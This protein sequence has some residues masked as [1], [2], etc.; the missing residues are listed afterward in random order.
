MAVTKLEPQQVFSKIV[1]TLFD[2][3]WIVGHTTNWAYQIQIVSGR[4]GSGNFLLEVGS[5]ITVDITQSGANGLDTGSEAANTWYFIWLIYNPT[6][7]TLAGLLSTSNSSPTMP[8]GYTEKRRI[9][10]VRND[11]SSN[12]LR[13][14]Q[15]GRK[16]LYASAVGQVLSFG[17]ATV[18]TAVDCSAFVPTNNNAIG[19][20]CLFASSVVGEVNNYAGFGVDGANAMTWVYQKYTAS[21]GDYMQ[22]A[23]A[24]YFHFANSN[25]PTV[26]YYNGGANGRFH[27]YILGFEVIV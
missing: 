25:P 5:T 4:V 17:S 14:V 8:S 11:S 15:F 20:H 1:T 24:G 13:F 2:N 7:G 21:V 12:L 19:V 16:V 22:D 3:V 10:A 26:Y 6:T 18:W 27:I 23:S 9:G